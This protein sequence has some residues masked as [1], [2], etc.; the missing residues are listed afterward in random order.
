LSVIPKDKFTVILLGNI[1]TSH[2][3]RMNITHEII[4]LLYDMPIASDKLR[5]SLYL[6]RALYQ[7]NLTD[8]IQEIKSNPDEFQLDRQGIQSLAQQVR[9]SGLA[10][11]EESILQLL[12]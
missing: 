8:A 12:N 5:A 9:W 1:G 4:S 10:A 2:Y 11:Q 6:H 3:E 7:G